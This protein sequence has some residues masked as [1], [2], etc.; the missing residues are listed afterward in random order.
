MHRIRN[1]LNLKGTLNQTNFEN[2][3][4]N[5]RLSIGSGLVIAFGKMARLELNYVLPLWKNINDK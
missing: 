2:L 1:K 5:T 4:S 3:I